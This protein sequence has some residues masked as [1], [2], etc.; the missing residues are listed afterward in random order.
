MV[1]NSNYFELTL[2]CSAQSC[3]QELPSLLC[4]STKE[5][6][7]CRI[8]WHGFIYLKL[9]YVFLSL[10]AFG[11]GNTQRTKCWACCGCCDFRRELIQAWGSAPLVSSFWRDLTLPAMDTGFLCKPGRGRHLTFSPPISLLVQPHQMLKLLIQKKRYL[12][13]CAWFCP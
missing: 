7:L 12:P 4:L 2:F 11:G 3:L 6:W 13:R 10:G 1:I 5:K 9:I 8:L